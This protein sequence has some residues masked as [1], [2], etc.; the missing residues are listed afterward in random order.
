MS[1][2]SVVQGTAPP[3]LILR[4]RYQNETRGGCRR[5]TMTI[6]EALEK[7][8]EGGYPKERAEDLALHVQA[9]YFLESTFW[10]AFVRALGVEGDFEY[11]HPDRGEPR[12]PRQP[13]WLYYW[14][15]F[16]SRLVAGKTPESFFAT[17]SP[18]QRLH[19]DARHQPP[20]FSDHRIRYV[21]PQ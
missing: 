4:A 17:F 14:H 9:Q 1:P 6:Q 11:I 5:V 3:S 8:I 19:N 16:N 2:V 7:A 20:Q 21:P 13:I 10:E 15:R 18:L 12:K